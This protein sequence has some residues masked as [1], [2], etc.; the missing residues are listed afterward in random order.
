MYDGGQ[1]IA[2]RKAQEL[3]RGMPVTA[4]S[5]EIAGLSIAQL[6]RSPFVLVG[7]WQKERLVIVRLGSD[8]LARSLALPK[9]S[10]LSSRHIKL[11][12]LSK[13]VVRFRNI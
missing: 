9:L 5:L 10:Q 1:H 4:Q 8:M 3:S 11:Q 13:S 6:S 2:D 7:H 12:L